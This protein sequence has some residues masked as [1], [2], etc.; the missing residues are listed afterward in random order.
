MQV[1]SPGNEGSFLSRPAFYRSRLQKIHSDIH[2][3]TE[4]F[5]RKMYSMIAIG[6]AGHE[7]ARFEFEFPFSVAAIDYYVETKTIE[8][9]KTVT[10][11]N[12]SLSSYRFKMQ[13]NPEYRKRGIMEALAKFFL[14]HLPENIELKYLIPTNLSDQAK[15]LFNKLESQGFVKLVAEVTE[16]RRLG[17]S[18]QEDSNIFHVYKIL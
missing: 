16:T 7:M 6:N 3:I 14:K 9:L 11:D 10:G 15:M 13:T 1:R 18:E 5:D 12:L 8:Q 4:K 2:G 17:A